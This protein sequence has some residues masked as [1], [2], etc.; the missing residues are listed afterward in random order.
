MT[1]TKARHLVFIYVFFTVVGMVNGSAAPIIFMYSATVDTSRLGGVEPGGLMVMTFTFDSE[2]APIAE[3][4]GRSTYRLTSATASAGSID[5]SAGGTGPYSGAFLTIENRDAV[6]S[7][8]FG[9][10]VS[11][12]F[13]RT[14]WDFTLTMRTRSTGK[15]PAVI[16]STALPLQQPDPAVFGESSATMSRSN[17]MGPPSTAVGSPAF[18]E[19]TSSIPEPSTMI[20]SGLICALGACGSILRRHIRVR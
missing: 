17:I 19:S 5:W 14:S 12:P 7:Y 4:P 6:D 1:F 13:G 3:E 18:R 20:T 2:V 16:T 15:P 10:S 8:L 11:P 9:G